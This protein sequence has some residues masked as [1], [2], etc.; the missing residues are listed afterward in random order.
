MWH[1]MSLW[2]RLPKHPNIVPFDKLV[3]DELEGRFVGFT[4]T[5]IP[6][7]TLEEN[8][9]RTFK[10]KWL[11][12]LIN[13]VDEL[14]LNLGVAHQDVAPRNLLINDVTDSLMIFDFN[15]SARIGQP[16]HL[17]ARN[18][19]KGVLFT[20]YEIITRNDD[21]RAVR[22]EEQ[23]VSIIEQQE[24]VKHPDVLIDHP[25]SEFRKV[26]TEWCEKRR[27]GEALTMHTDAPNFLDWPP[28]PDPPLSELK[29]LLADGTTE[30]E[31]CKRYDW[32]R[33]EL[34]EEGKPFLDWQRPSQKVLD[35]AIL[36]EIGSE[37]NESKPSEWRA[38]EADPLCDVNNV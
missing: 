24:W 26:L 36:S 2:M 28:F 1:E 29:I 12:Q 20:M 31:M 11:H 15:F 35:Q 5:Y 32:K 21:L 3:V 6:G 30:T 22:H 33:N 13:V 16:G 10:L 27:K 14:N 23:D 4:T 38:G 37:G 8:K 19:I 18:D 34:R 25:V 17:E 9:R 7:G